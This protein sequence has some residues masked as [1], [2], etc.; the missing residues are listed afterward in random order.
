MKTSIQFNA[1]IGFLFT[2][3]P[4][5]GLNGDKNSSINNT[6]VMTEKYYSYLKI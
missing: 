1:R 2:R 3:I 6:L 4:N 5:M